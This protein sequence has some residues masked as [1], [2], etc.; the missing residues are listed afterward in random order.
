MNCILTTHFQM[1]YEITCWPFQ[2]KN[3]NKMLTTFISVCWLGFNTA[4]GPILKLYVCLL[5]VCSYHTLNGTISDLRISSL[6]MFYYL[7][8]LYNW[9]AGCVWKNIPQWVLMLQYARMQTRSVNLVLGRITL[10]SCKEPTS[11][12]CWHWDAWKAISLLTM[13]VNI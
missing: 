9:V 10:S 7:Q 1:N 11:V 8:S 4:F 13:N 12:M 3:T 5:E 2:T 6:H